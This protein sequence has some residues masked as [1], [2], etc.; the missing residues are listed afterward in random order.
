MNFFF[1]FKK[2][3]FC[4]IRKV[5]VKRVGLFVSFFYLF[6]LIMDFFFSNYF[7]SYIELIFLVFS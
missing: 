7:I 6:V 1:G 2:I 4:D 3:N 5:L